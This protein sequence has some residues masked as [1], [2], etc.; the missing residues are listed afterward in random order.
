M[1]RWAERITGDPVSASDGCVRFQVQQIDVFAKRQV[2]DAAPFFH[3]QARRQDP[4]KANPAGGVNLVSE[5]CF[6]KRP[7]KMRWQ[8]HAQEHQDCPHGCPSR[9][10]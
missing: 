3:D 4:G 9:F 1:G 7:A 6:E 10:R 5:S 2:T 8:A